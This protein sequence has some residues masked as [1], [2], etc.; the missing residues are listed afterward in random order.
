MRCPD[1]GG[2]LR[3]LE[4]RDHVRRRRCDLGHEHVTHEVFVGQQGDARQA[5]RLAPLGPTQRRVVQAL[6]GRALTVH[7]LMA[8]LQDAS[9]SRVMDAIRGLRSRKMVY[10]AGY[11]PREG[12]RAGRRAPIYALGDHADARE[13]SVPRVER[14]RKYRQ[15]KT[16][17]MWSGLL[18]ASADAPRS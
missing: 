7:G 1:C 6:D 15:R 17:G 5:Q 4:T 14:D 16:A 13:P 18:T 11:A 12:A 8:A 9:R 2:K 3:V 10:V